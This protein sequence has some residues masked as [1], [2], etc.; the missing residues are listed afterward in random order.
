MQVVCC[1][2]DSFVNKRIYKATIHSS[3]P[4]EIGVV[5]WLFV[6]VTGDPLKAKGVKCPY[7]LAEDLRHVR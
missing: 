6:R 3:L 5:D 1:K 2:T 4:L 7:G